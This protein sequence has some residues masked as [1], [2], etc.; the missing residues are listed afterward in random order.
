MRRLVLRLR[1]GRGV[2]PAQGTPQYTSCVPYALRTPNASRPSAFFAA[3]AF[4]ALI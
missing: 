2:D 1:A 3:W 4:C